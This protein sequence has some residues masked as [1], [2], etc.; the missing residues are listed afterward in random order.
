MQ[1]FFKERLRVALSP[2]YTFRRN[3]LPL[4]PQLQAMGVDGRDEVQQTGHDNKLCTVVCRDDLHHILPPS[5]EGRQK[6]EQPVS[7]I[8]KKSQ[9][10]ETDQVAGRGIDLSMHGKAKREHG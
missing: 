7:E 4:P 8:A 3:G 6:E 2:I 1:P 10:V 5:A 9:H